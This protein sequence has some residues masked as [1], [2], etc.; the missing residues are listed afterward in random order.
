[1]KKTI[2]ILLSIF[3]SLSVVFAQDARQRSVETIVSDVLAAMPAQ[4]SQSFKE[5]M[6]DLAKSAPKSVEILAGMLTPASEGKNNLIEYA[7]S[8]VTD[9][10][11]DP[12][13]AQYKAA[14]L[15][16]LK[17]GASKMTDQFNR[18][19]M[20]FYARLLGPVPAQAAPA[21][22]TKADLAAAKKLLTSGNSGEKCLAAQTLISSGNEKNA[23]KVLSTALKS[24]DRPLRN[25]AIGFAADKAGVPAVASAL[26][27]A[28]PK[29]AGSAKTDAIN[30][31]GNHKI[32]DAVDLVLSEV[33]GAGE[34]GE[35]AVIAAG[36]I[37]GQKVLSTL[38]G[39]LSKGGEKADQAFTALK[40]FKGDIKPALLGA[41]AADKTNTNLLKLASA[42]HMTS[43]A[44]NLLSLASSSDASV[45]KSAA[46]LLPGLATLAD[47]P[48]VAGLLDKAP[49][50]EVAPLQSAFAAT[51]KHETPAQVFETV[52]GLIGSMKNPSRLYPALASSGTDEAVDFLKNAY[53]KG[54]A[55]ALGN[56]SGVNNL[57]AAPVLLSAIKADPVKN[58]SLLDNYVNIISSRETDLGKKL[59]NLSE[60]I[61]LARSAAQ[62][63]KILNQISSIPTMKAFLQAGKS[64]ADPEKT[65]A[66]AAANAVKN[67]AAKTTEEIDYNALKSNLQKAQ[68]VF[69]STGNT[70]DGYAVDEIN[71][72]LSKAAPSPVSELTA[73]EKRMGFEMLFDGTDLSKWQGDLEG[74]TPVN[75]TILVSAGY[76]AE[77]NLYT[78]K[79]Y[80]D[81][82]YRFEFCFLR[83]GENNGVGIRTPM[84]VDA[85]YHGMCEVQILDHDAPIY[86]NLHEYQVHGSVYGVI[87]AKRIVHKPLG[88][89]GTEEIVVKGNHIKVT[90]NGEVVVDGDI[91]KA[92]KGH[93]VAPDGSNYNPYTVDHRNHPGM[94]NKDGYISFCGHG[95]G[96][97]LRNIRILD[98]SK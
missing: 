75:G 25:A 13:N 87:P 14:V 67:I 95:A 49:A 34:L 38:I 9:F 68:D 98:L 96:L 77:G 15:E 51:V 39:L 94:F 66:Y 36:K 31:L 90:V 10:A 57:K 53:E 62:K 23:L 79:K 40:A 89:W 24:T 6:A 52:K 55:E 56:L 80:K 63:V 37:G 59:H 81:F 20:N 27:K 54:D 12:A 73:E 18:Q 83:E 8:G 29:L 69:R 58:S 42:M 48:V 71:T 11:S 4:D 19:L 88:E 85:A 7:I 91:R 82:I 3:L 97:K 26:M 74:Y 72:I 76:G 84:G 21:A 30:F 44:P 93:N 78:K 33:A 1:M 65:V 60:A 86:A 43:A 17:N 92:C 16:G 61:G 2:S 45:R 64:L 35:T 70:D 41:I 32:N 46:Q 50:D 28:Y 22:P 47:A 5:N